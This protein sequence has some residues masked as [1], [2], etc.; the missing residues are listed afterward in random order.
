MNDVDVLVIG[1]GISGLATAW[2]LAREGM[3]VEVW[4]AADRP[5]GKIQSVRNDGYLTEQ[6]AAL[7]MNFRP[8]VTE[9]MRDAGLE[10]VRTLRSTTAQ[11]HRYLLHQGR[12]TELPMRLGSLVLSPLWSL[13]AKLRLLA[14]PLIPAGDNAQETVSQFITRRLGREVLE[15]AMDPFIAGTLASDPNQASAASTLPRLTNLETHYGSITAG[16][17]MN[18]L[19]RRRTATGA[20]LFSFRGGME[21]LIKTLAK[22]PG[23]R[24]RTSHTVQELT[25]LR[26]GWRVTADGHAGFRAR[27]IVLATPAPVTARLLVP[28]DHELATLLRGIR[29]APLAAVHFGIDRNAVDHPLDGNGFLVPAKEQQP[30]N[31]NLW[32]S[33][34]FP[35][36]APT[37]KVLLTSYLG[38][39]RHPEIMTWDDQRLIET[40]LQALSPLLGIRS[41]PE[42]TRIDRHRQALPLYHGA[43]PQ[44]LAAIDTCLRRHPGLF[45]EANYRGGVSVRDRIAHSRTVAQ[46]MMA[47]APRHAMAA[48]SVTA[49][50]LAQDC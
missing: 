22:T 23:V 46:R 29:Y 7:L 39:A 2:W 5:G 48:S 41:A 45:L 43:Y 47:T 8:E 38:G 18:K 28:L 27:Q 16:I 50:A 25:P 12:L 37:G 30:F 1:G 40:T 35:D 24:L 42:M 11:Q 33:S 21:T 32:L 34:L 13:Q 14:E 26:G 49:T 31:G 44:R 36:R 17:L 6:A 15:K 10:N 3:D 9:L 20:E 4:E 19:L